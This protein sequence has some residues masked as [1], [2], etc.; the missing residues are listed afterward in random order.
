M[1]DTMTPRAQELVALIASPNVPA[2]TQEGL[3]KGYHGMFFEGDLTL[4]GKEVAALIKARNWAALSAK[5]G[6]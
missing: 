2:K 4:I 6:I 3:R 5:F 1:S